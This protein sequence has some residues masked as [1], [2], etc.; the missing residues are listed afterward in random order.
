MLTNSLNAAIEGRPS[1]M[2]GSLSPKLWTVERY[3]RE[4]FDFPKIQYD[5]IACAG[6]SSIKHASITISSRDLNFRS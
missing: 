1:A 4:G 2:T 6:L 3:V 5:P